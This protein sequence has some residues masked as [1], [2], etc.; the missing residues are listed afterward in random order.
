MVSKTEKLDLIDL[1]INFQRYQFTR[2]LLSIPRYTGIVLHHMGAGRYTEDD[3]NPGYLVHQMHLRNGYS[4]IGYGGIVT[5]AGEYFT[6]RPWLK[7]GA[8]CAQ[9]GYADRNSDFGLLWFGGLEDEPA[10]DALFAIAKVLAW[11]CIDQGVPCNSGTIKGHRDWLPNQCPGNL[12]DFIPRLI[13]MASEIIDQVSRGYSLNTEK[14]KD[15]AMDIQPCE[16]LMADGETRAALL[17]DGDSWVKVG[18]L[19]DSGTARLQNPP[20]DSVNKR[21]LFEQ[22]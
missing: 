10:A 8:H 22:G 16:A 17:I 11:V 20:W 3:R 9:R 7:R 21:V 6:G 13:G 12:Y 2:G 5:Q 14:K 1:K 4:G 19:R 15:H 18:D